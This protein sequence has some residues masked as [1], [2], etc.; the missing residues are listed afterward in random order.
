VVPVAAQVTPAAQKLETPG[1]PVV[2][3]VIT[4]QAVQ[5]LQVK[6][7]LVETDILTLHLMV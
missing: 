1:V 6:A 7:L 3:V 5:E 2:V 4:V